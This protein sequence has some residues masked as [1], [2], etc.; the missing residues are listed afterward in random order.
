MKGNSNIFSRK[1]LL[2][3]YVPFKNLA[4]PRQL[5]FASPFLD[6]SFSKNHFV[7]RCLGTGKF[8]PINQIASFNFDNSKKPLGKGQLS[9][10]KGKQQKNNERLLVKHDV[11]NI[12]TPS[13]S[14]QIVFPLPTEA[15]HVVLGQRTGWGVEHVRCPPLHHCMNHA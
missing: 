2:S 12:R 4:V 10:S 15:K 11:A 8:L 7:P 1:F 14:R 9:K 3:L 5:F 6:F 13:A